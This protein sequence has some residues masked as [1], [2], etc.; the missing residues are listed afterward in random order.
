MTS[1]I[2]SAYGR[3]NKN[4]TSGTHWICFPPTFNAPDQSFVITKQ[5]R[6]SAALPLILNAANSL[7]GHLTGHLIC[8]TL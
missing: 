2:A 1:V 8:N 5:S 6:F 3:S 4:R 7:S